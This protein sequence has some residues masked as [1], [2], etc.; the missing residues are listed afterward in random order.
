M[1]YVLWTFLSAGVQS[2]PVA[3][4]P[5]GVQCR[6]CAALVRRHVIDVN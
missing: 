5:G 1:S 2:S 3:A 6:A 4:V